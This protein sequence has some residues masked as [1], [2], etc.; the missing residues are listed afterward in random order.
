M[1]MV[2]TSSSAPSIMAMVSVTC[3]M[4]IFLP[5]ISSN[6]AWSSKSQRFDIDFHKETDRILSILNEAV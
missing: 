4:S 6:C 3:L 2:R 5:P 1:V